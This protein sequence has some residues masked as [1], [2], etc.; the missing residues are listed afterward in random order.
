MKHRAGLTCLALASALC[1]CESRMEPPPTAPAPPALSFDGTYKLSVQVT[2]IASG[3]QI[4]WCDTTPAVALQVTNNAFT[5]EQ[6]HPNVPA[7]GGGSTTTIYS[8][9]IAPD[10]TIRGTSSNGGVLRGQVTGNRMSGSISGIGCYYN[11]TAE[12]A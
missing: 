11:F 1:A 2:G 10:G 7:Q 6:P 3:G 4:S 9:S 8:V 5:Y 12:K